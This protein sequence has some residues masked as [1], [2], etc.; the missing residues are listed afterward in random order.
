MGQASSSSPSPSSLIVSDR[1]DRSLSR[2]FF[3]A[4]VAASMSS[5]LSDDDYVGEPLTATDGYDYTSDIPDEC[6]ACIFQSLPS[7]D[8]KQCS[9]VCH[10][11]FVV[12]GQSRHRLSLNA[13]ADVVPDLPTLF[14]RFDSVT[15]LSL[16][17]DRR[18]ASLGDEALNLISLRCRNLKRLKLRGCRELTD[19]GITVF[20][21]NCRALKKL[22]CG[23]CMFGAKGLN[24]ILNYCA[25]LEEISVKRLRSLKDGG[26]QPEPIGP[27]AAAASLKII[28][29]KELYNG[30]CFAPLVIGSRK[31][32]TLKVFRCLGEWDRLLVTIGDKNTS[33][34]EVHL[35]RLQGCRLLRKLHIDG[36]RTN[37]IGDEGLIAVA[38]NCPNLQELVLIGVNPT[39][40]SLTA[41]AYNC[42]NLERLALCGSESI[43]DEEIVCISEKCLA[44]R[45]LCIKGCP[46]SDHGMKSLAWGFPNLVKIKVKKCR[47]VTSDIAGWLQV[48]RG[49]LVVIL[50]GQTDA[51]DAIVQENDSDVPRTLVPAATE[52]AYMDAPSSSTS[53]ST[54]FRSR[55]SLFTGRSFVACTFR[56]WTNDNSDSKN[57]QL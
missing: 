34:T 1:R 35:E 31:L 21:Q 28:S 7:V 52:I 9:L 55:F 51:S 27:G 56:R 43:R 46:I 42:R 49:S 24:A 13:S 41:L 22:S 36:W 14:S 40:L 17:C 48:N 37:R 54:P 39:L 57:D 11:W 32:K 30:Q 25:G 15:K 4:S 33:L 19:A 8:R 16:R 5:I 18:S 12:E 23:S 44:L 45:K 29:L 38:K 47:G 50:D 2:R 6:L 53:R 20:A 26:G 10:R 3:S